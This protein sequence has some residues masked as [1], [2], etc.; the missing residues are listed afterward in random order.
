MN[1]DTLNFEV[2]D[3]KDA[4]Y[5]MKMVKCQDACPVH[6]DACGYVTA[7]A[8]GRD[9]DAYKIA[10]ATNP[11]ASICGRVCGA[12]CEANCRRGSLDTPITIR[13]LKRFVN[14]K[15]GPE[16]GDFTY[17]REGCNTKMLPPEQGEGESVAIVG[18]GVAGLTVAHDLVQLGYKVTVFEAYDEPGGMLTAGVP[19]YRLPRELVRAEIDAILSMGVELKCNQ[20]LGRD[21]TIDGL[22]K[23]GYKAIFLGIGL[24]K[25]RKIPIGGA[26]LPQVFDGLDFLRAF[27]EGKPMELGRR[28]V[29]IGGGNVAFD[30]ARSAVRP[31][32]VPMADAASDMERTER[33]AYDVARSALRLSGDKEV[34]IVCLEKR[35]EMPADEIE[36]D[37]GEEE[38]IKLHAERGPRLIL[39]EEGYVTGL[40]TVKCLSVFDENGR[41][42]PVYDEDYVED[43]PADTIMFAIGQQSDLSFLQ[44]ADGVDVE[45]GLIKVDP[46]TYQ[47]TAP[48]VFACGDVAHGPR[49]FIHAIASAQIAARSMHDY[50]RGTRTDVVVR[51]SW[52]PANYTMV[53]GWDQLRRKLPPA[54]DSEKR[55]SSNEIVEINYSE[56]EARKQASR[57][58]RCNVNTV[59]DTSIC[60]ACNGCVDVCPENLIKL[61]GLNQVRSDRGLM[62]IASHSLG[63]TE[64]DLAVYTNEELAELGGIMIKDEST[65]IRCAM[66]ASRC[67]THAIEMKQFNYKR[68]CV[69][70]HARNPKIKYNSA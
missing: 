22:R 32:K 57:C 21:F 3:Q 37:E 62:Q 25:G 70:I 29:V 48:D 61:V 45:N 23:D 43:I 67:P 18:A 46:D 30:V 47:T 16:S 54:L 40:R 66:C 6:T 33:I 11:F 58:L 24:Q 55:A 52:S 19:I 2:A 28:I 50:L 17:Y 5:W 56:S 10:R 12:P 20:R 42:S 53:E 69:T 63:I 51:K 39:D 44:P 65:C 4:D 38:G 13:A 35:S 26:D 68:E 1:N 36:I 41:F 15:Y 49:L 14:E 60:I 31:L 59:F 64:A 8:E 7:I 34:H 9:L 27:N